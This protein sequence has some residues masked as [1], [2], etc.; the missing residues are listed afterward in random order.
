MSLPCQT[1]KG[2][3]RGQVTDSLGNNFSFHHNQCFTAWK[4]DKANKIPFCRLMWQYVLNALQTYVP[5]DTVILFP[6][7]P[8]SSLHSLSLWTWVF[9]QHAVTCFGCSAFV[10]QDTIWM[11]PWPSGLTHSFKQLQRAPK[12]LAHFTRTATNTERH[13]IKQW[14]MNLI[15]HLFSHW[16]LKTYSDWGSGV[17]TSCISGTNTLHSSSTTY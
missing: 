7:I 10:L 16:C 11:C 5:F 3:L 8:S 1:Q 17:K 15:F 12:C 4:H 6:R 14:Q 9:V 2:D 13:S